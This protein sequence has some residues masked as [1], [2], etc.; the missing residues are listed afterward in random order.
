MNNLIE[1][2]IQT[3]DDRQLIEM[4]TQTQE[5][6]KEAREIETQTNINYMVNSNV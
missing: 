6:G 1:K 3:K 2:G 5:I 4:E